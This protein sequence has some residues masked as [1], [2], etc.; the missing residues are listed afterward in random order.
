MKKILLL[1]VSACMLISLFSCNGDGVTS[2]TTTENASDVTTDNTPDETTASVDE[3]TSNDVETT[4]SSADDTTASTP[5]ASAPLTEADWA[6][7]LSEANFENY[8]FVSEGN[9]T[10]TSNGQTVSETYMKEKVKV[11]SDKME[12][13]MFDNGES[14]GTLLFEDAIAKEQKTQYSQIFIALLKNYSNFEYDEQTKTY[15]VNTTVTIEENLKG[16]TIDNTTGEMISFE[17]PTVIEMRSAELKLSDDGKLLT[18]VCDYTQ[19]MTLQ[20][21]TFTSSALTT[22]SFSDFGTTV[23]A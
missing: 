13:E 19:T 5:D 15:K 3:T 14:V 4:T 21:Q 9:T 1:I 22:W 20:G 23:I 7:L 17:T 10:I 8:T 18:F 6:A 2:D 11:T 12:L 16:V